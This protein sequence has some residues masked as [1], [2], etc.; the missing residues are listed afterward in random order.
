MPRGRTC[1]WLAKE[2]YP[3]AVPALRRA[4]PWATGHHGRRERLKSGAH[5]PPVTSLAGLATPAGPRAV[6]LIPAG[7][8]AACVDSA[9]QGCPARL[10]AVAILK[11]SSVCVCLCLVWCAW[12]RLH[13]G[14]LGLCLCVWLGV[15]FIHRESGQCQ[16]GERGHPPGPGPDPVG[17][18][19]PLSCPGEPLSLFPTPHVHPTG[20]LRTSS[21]ELRLGQIHTS[22]EKGSPAALHRG[23][24]ASC[25]CTA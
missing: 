4:W 5:L 20:T 10:E 18:E 7:D 13:L 25:L 23:S 19:Q 9:P 2:L 15:P 3:P 8:G 22:I 24:G 21:A 1:W 12:V 16:R 17:A 14:T 11:C 6:G